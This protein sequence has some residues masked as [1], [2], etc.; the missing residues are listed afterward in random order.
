MNRRVLALV[1]SSCLLP[2]CP[3]CWWSAKLPPLP[4][5]DSYADPRASQGLS[6]LG[7]L[8]GGAEKK[9][10]APETASRE[11]QI[12]SPQTLEL[13]IR[14]AI[15]MALESN[16]ELRVERLNPRII[17]TFED[18]ERAAFD[19]L[20]TAAVSGG[21]TNSQRQAP[22]GGGTQTSATNTFSGSIG[23]EQFLPTG[24]TI[25]AS[26]TSTLTDS[27]IHT[28]KFA[29]TRLG[30]SVTQALLRGFGVAVN[31]ASLRQARLDTLASHYELRAFAETL[32]A[33]VEKTYWDCALAE[34]QIE[35]VTQSLAL[36]EQQLAETEE[37]IRIGKLADTERAAAQA[38]VASRREALIQ[39][40]G[41]LATARLR[42]LRLLNPSQAPRQAQG[43]ANL[44][45][46]AGFWTRQLV[47]RTQPIVPE[48]GL[49][50][51]ES[52]A[53]L[54]LAMRP[55]LAEARLRIRQGD[56]ELVKTRNG[57]LPKLDLFMTLGKSGYADSFG[58][59][60][61]DLDGE[62]YDAL[63]GA[64]L[65]FPIL[66]RAARARHQRATLTREQLDEALANLAQL[67]QL[68]VRTAY[69]EVTRAREQ[70]A[71]TAA[72]RSFREEAL[73]A[74]TEKFRVG[75]STTL[76]VAQA[77]RDLVQSQI[78]EVQAVVSLLKG[79]VDLY[80]L[81]GSLLERRGITA[82]G[83]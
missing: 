25:E 43:A 32:V 47:L 29:A 2:A 13:D 22:G 14:D 78:A 63:V 64:S 55:D 36:A 48:G 69:I 28:S 54:A 8:A 24:T 11:S 41:A 45:H 34:R 46:A 18:E 56:L 58:G 67:A 40:R 57:L 30:L 23:A 20:L 21:R 77:Q 6:D 27:S 31:L 70:V 66:N 68:D 50:D 7:S 38:E 60:V 61:R 71:A 42:L 39:A 17:Q 75:K 49:D 15:L 62:S 9:P 80:R 12:A 83:R 1:A 19:P 5:G 37:R 53:Q 52:H 76:L 4:P 72:T 73:R 81:E 74:E 79:L 16:Q 59:S 35:I 82:P 3:G 51:V 65:E 44:E 10:A 33:D 26:A